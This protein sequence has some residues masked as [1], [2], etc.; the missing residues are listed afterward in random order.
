[1]CF[2]AQRTGDN[3]HKMNKAST[4]VD[5]NKGLPR[6]RMKRGFTLIELLVVIAIIGILAGLL[7][8]ALAKAKERAKMIQCTNSLHQI[9]IA[10]TMYAD[11]NN[12]YFFYSSDDSGNLALPNGGQWYINPRSSVME[13]VFPPGADLSNGYWAL[14]YYSYYGRNQKVF[15]CPDGTVVDE[16]K[17]GGLSYPHDFWANSSYGICDY[18][19]FPYKKAGSQYGTN[20]PKVLKRSG[21]LSPNT[22]IFCMDSTEQKVEDN[23]DLLAL[24]PGS[25][26]SEILTQW[27]DT[28]SEHAL[29]G[30]DMTAGWFRHNDACLV[31]W[32]GGNVSRIK[33]SEVP[34]KVGIDY[35]FYTGEVPLTQPNF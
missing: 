26:Y 10:A 21:L 7:L 2:I 5:T 34:V 4:T 12:D 28:S 22:T 29:Y 25:G 27:N 19:L 18:L 14:G 30:K 8:P 1:M 35:R 3:D 17:D 31:L 33:R 23:G 6:A 15:G 13:N 11:D 32:V 9:G 20:P 24:V 16:W